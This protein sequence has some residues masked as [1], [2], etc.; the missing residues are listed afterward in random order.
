VP[1]LAAGG[2]TPGLLSGS[3]QQSTQP[4]TDGRGITKAEI[5][6]IRVVQRHFYKKEI[7]LLVN[8][9]I[10]AGKSPLCCL[11]PYLNSD[12]LIMMGGRLERAPLTTDEKHPIIL[13]ALSHLAKLV[14]EACHRRALHGGPQ[15]TLALVRQRFWIP[16]G[17]RLTKRVIHHCI[18]CLRWRAAAAT[19]KMGNLPGPR[20]NPARPFLYAGVNY[21]GP[22]FLRT[23]P[24]RRYKDVKAFL[25]IFVCLS[26]RAVHLDVASS[27]STEAFLAAFRRFVSRRGMCVELFND[28]G[29]NF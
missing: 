7:K 18:T 11:N 13:P 20:V 5:Q 15:L 29:T 9:K 25:V 8:N 10:I 6:W 24:G 23:T 22:V 28:C 14:V 2:K 16:Q 3:D 12:E 27:Y 1:T 17:R 21:A 4:P 19:Q 26:T